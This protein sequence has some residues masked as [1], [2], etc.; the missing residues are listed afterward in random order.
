VVTLHHILVQADSRAHQLNRSVSSAVGKVVGVVRGSIV[1]NV[2]KL[3]EYQHRETIGVLRALL[4]RAVAGRIAG[5]AISMQSDGAE[6]AL[7]TGVYKD[8]PARAV[9][10]AMR[11]SWRL[12]QLQDEITGPP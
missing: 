9:N 12:T 5:L 6:T 8:N 4:A 1:G 7:F 10:A 2:V 11:Q 3:V